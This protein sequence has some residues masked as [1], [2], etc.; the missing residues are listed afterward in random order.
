MGKNILTWQLEER[1][2]QPS[3]DNMQLKKGKEENL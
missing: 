3:H 1:C 2:K